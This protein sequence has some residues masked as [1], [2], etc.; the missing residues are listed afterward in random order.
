MVAVRS[1]AADDVE[2]AGRAITGDGEAFAQLFERWFDRAFDVAWHIVRN[3]DTA[4]DVAQETFA[5]AWQQIGTLRQ[6]ESFGGWLL[7]IARNKGLNRLAH[8]QRSRPVGDEETLAMHDL[9]HRT[10]DDPAEPLVAGERDDLVWAASVA[11]GDDD[12]SLLSLH[13]RHGLGAGELADELGIAANAA[14]QRLFRLKKRL[15][16]AIGA[17]TLWHRGSPSCPELRTLLSNAGTTRFD[18]DASSMI[19]AHTRGCPDCESQRTLQLSPE[20]L[21]ASVPLVAAGPA[22]RA[23]AAAALHSAGVPSPAS[24]SPTD[25][26]SDST[27][28]DR[29][30]PGGA[31]D[32][33]QTAESHAGEGGGRGDGWRSGVRGR[34]LLVLAAAVSVVWALA[35]FAERTGH[36]TVDQAA[37]PIDATTTRPDDDGSTTTAAETTSSS[38]NAPAAT[39]P[40][41]GPV[42]APTTSPPPPPTPTTAPT[43]TTASTVPPAVAPVV[44]GFRATPGATCGSGQVTTVFAWSSTGG[45]SALLGPTGGIGGPVDPS[46]TVT[47]C[48]VVGSSWSLV[49]TGPGGRDTAQVTV[50]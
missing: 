20:A 44:G 24:A 46:G 8:E 2:L 50:A 25:A 31:D 4:A 15:G 33:G 6:P 16:D 12:A 17:W 47:R 45:E 11:L 21:F 43:T 29:P 9:D 10:G 35:L 41:E 38:P 7:R 27:P 32:T 36:G 28:A 3:R 22:L 48:A 18:R 1:S 42:V 40:G 23:Q 30:D 37:G 19:A 26:P 14:H 13:L 39:T 49:V 34:A 5:T